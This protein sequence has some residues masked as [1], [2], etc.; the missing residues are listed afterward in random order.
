MKSLQGYASNFLGFVNDLV[1]PTGTGP[2]VFG[3]AM[4]PFQREFFN[5]VAPSLLAVMRQQ[6]PPV[7]AFWLE[8]VKGASKDSDVAL[9]L[10]WLLAFSKRALRM[11]VGAFDQQQAS[12][13]KLIVEDVLR[14]ERPLNKFLRQVVE[15]QTSKIVNPHTDSTIFVLSTDKLGSHGSRPDVVVL[16][17][18]AHQGVDSTFASTLLDNASKMPC[19]LV[20]V[21]TNSGFVDSWQEKW[22]TV[23]SQTRRW[24]VLEHKSRPP[25]IPSESWQEAKKRNSPNRYLRLFKGVWTGSTEGALDHDDIRACTTSQRPMTGRE[26]G[27]CFYGGLDIGVRKHATGLIIIGKNFGWSEEVTAKKPPMSRT[28]EALV[29]LGVLDAPP[30]ETEYVEHDGTGQLRLAYA[31][32][33]KP[34]PGRRVSL[35]DV[36]RTILRLHEIFD[37]EGLAVDPAQGEH[38]IELC[39]KDNVPVERCI[40][41]V[42]SLQDQA[43]AIIEC[44]QQK[45]IELYPDSDLIAD[46][47]K[48]QLRD[49]G[50]RIRLLSPEMKKRKNQDQDEQAGTGH[51]DLASGLSFAVALARSRMSSRQNRTP[52]DIIVY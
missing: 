37:L 33:W 31:E 45:T 5:A 41:S 28:A 17:E 23:F 25:W 8:R 27:W 6:S 1:I 3:D 34:L 40:Q 19:C 48:L 49:D 26:K 32:S 35:E 51:G 46:L 39:E 43:L 13:V 10:L 38:L 18:L 44:F 2:K 11:E 21:A 12:E 42:A 16:D 15:V 36:R 24:S 20:V 7:P 22:K 50:R 29:D 14:I 47:K 4:A 52:A 30:E 9:C